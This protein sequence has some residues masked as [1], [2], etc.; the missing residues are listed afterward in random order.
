MP[1]VWLPFWPKNAAHSA[2]LIDT[3]DIGEFSLVLLILCFVFG[4]ML[5]FCMKYR[6]GSGAPRHLPNP[7]SWQWEIGWTAATLVAFLVLFVIGAKAYL[8]LYKPPAHYQLEL[9]V[10]G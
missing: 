8:F 7:K 9:Y 4:M 5:V 3:I 10:V 1:Q 6:R 2:S